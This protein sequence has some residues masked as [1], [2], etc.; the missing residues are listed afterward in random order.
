MFTQKL[1][2]SGRYM[3]HGN[4]LTP[5][6]RAERERLFSEKPEYVLKIRTDSLCAS[7]VYNM[8][9]YSI[10]ILDDSVMYDYD[11]AMY[12]YGETGMDLPV[13]IQEWSKN[14]KKYWKKEG[15][16]DYNGYLRNQPENGN[17]DKYTEFYEEM[18]HP[19]FQRGDGSEHFTFYR[20]KREENCTCSTIIQFKRADF[21]ETE[22]GQRFLKRVRKFFKKREENLV[23]ISLYDKYGRMVRAFA[24]AKPDKKKPVYTASAAEWTQQDESREDYDTCEDSWKNLRPEDRAE[25]DRL[26]SEKPEYVLKISAYSSRGMYIHDMISYSLGILNEFSMN[27]YE[28]AP[29]TAISVEE[30][31]E[32][33][34]WEKN[35]EN[36]WK[37]EGCRSYRDFLRKKPEPDKLDKYTDF[38]KNM[39]HP[40]FQT[41]EHCDRKT[42]YNEKFNGNGAYTAIIQL[43][44]ADFAETEVGQRL[45]SRI[46]EFYEE[47]QVTVYSLSL[48]DKDER[49]LKE[50]PSVEPEKKNPVYING[51]AGKQMQLY[52]V[53]VAKGTKEGH[54]NLCSV[55]I[56]GNRIPS[57][58][59]ADAFCRDKLHLQGFDFVSDV[60]PIS[61]EDAE[62]DFGIKDAGMVPEFQSAGASRLQYFEAAFAKGTPD[63]YTSDYSIC[64]IGR[65]KPTAE[66]A[67]EFCKEDLKRMKYDFVSD[68]TKISR[69]QAHRFFDM[70]HED[71]FPIFS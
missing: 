51:A 39:L 61:A 53:L 19:T 63:D 4:D 12:N 66:E 68:V 26:L 15:C 59:E 47:K 2:C 22:I 46:R 52:Q 16:M 31:K 67:S 10:G 37:A 50:F 23:S 54:V 45:L 70:E 64:I 34:T 3:G 58:K 40:T 8:L 55:C 49:L 25:R 17:Q 48:Y 65:R 11:S 56:A 42:F 6:E 36:Y 41:L 43:K 21:A 30:R 5:E 27:K 60:F 24:A 32:M 9:A 62:R 28:F 14:F 1:D 7:Y 44:R 18:L 71:A 20:V 13:R 35:F 29:N 33:Y 57:K 38:Y 69:E